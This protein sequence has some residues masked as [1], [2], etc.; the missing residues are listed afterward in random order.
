MLHSAE[1]IFRNEY[2]PERGPTFETA[3]AHE[4]GPPGELFKEKS[5][6]ENLVKLS[7]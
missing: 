3:L 7:L 4:S 5:R 6:I 1:S 2:I